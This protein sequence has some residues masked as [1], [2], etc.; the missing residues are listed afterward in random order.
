VDSRYRDGRRWRDFYIGFKE[1]LARTPSLAEDALLRTAAT[2]AAAIDIMARQVANG[3]RPDDDAL[4]KS[5]GSLR[6]T[7]AALG[8]TDAG[9]PAKG[10][11]DSDLGDLLGAS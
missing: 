4:A 8:L 5:S 6:R 1:A 9:S 3:R 7:L 2:Q 10:S 11:S